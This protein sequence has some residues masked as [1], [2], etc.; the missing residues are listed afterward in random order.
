MDIL[1]LA[2]MIIFYVVLIAALLIIPLSFPGTWVMVA[3]AIVYAL[4]G[5]LNPP[6]GSEW[7]PILV[8]V[9]LAGLGELIELGVRIVGSKMAAVPNGAIVAAIIGGI[10][11]AIVGV[12]IFLIGSLLGLLLGVFVGALLYSLA[13]VKNTHQALK[14]ALATTTSQ[15]VA[16]F[17]KTCIGLG[18]M[19]YITMELF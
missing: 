19:V 15:I 7:F 18:M 14:M 4:L 10:I 11:G 12:P 16:L 6:G 2:G 17:A 1:S 9:L 3:A 13:H 8:L 5:D